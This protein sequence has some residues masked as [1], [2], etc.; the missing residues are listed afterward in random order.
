MAQM[1]VAE[2]NF[3]KNLSFVVWFLKVKYVWIV[4]S[5]SWVFVWLP[6]AFVV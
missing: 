2:G 3:I 4:R 1:G 5:N 6:F